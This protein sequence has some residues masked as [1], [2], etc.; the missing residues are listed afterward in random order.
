MV[1]TVEV[2]DLDPE[3]TEVLDLVVGEEVMEVA[4]VTEVVLAPEVV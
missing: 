4:A 2:M 3:A 1:V